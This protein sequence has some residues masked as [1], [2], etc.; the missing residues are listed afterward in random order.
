MS[1][2][3]GCNSSASAP[4]VEET[5]ATV[6]VADQGWATSS[7]ATFM[8]K[9]VEHEGA[10]EPVTALLFALMIFAFLKVLKRRFG[11]EPVIVLRLDEARDQ[12]PESES[13]F[14]NS[15]S[16]EETF[17]PRAVFRRMMTW[18]RSAYIAGRNADSTPAGLNSTV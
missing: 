15:F 14:T 3:C 16:N 2:D 11:S 17:Q 5:L 12:R 6:P 8:L 4:C 18:F 9:S 1:S 10:A 7:S 13:I